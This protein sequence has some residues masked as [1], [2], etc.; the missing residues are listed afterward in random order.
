MLQSTAGTTV[1]RGNTYFGS[2]LKAFSFLF[3]F[4]GII[5]SGLGSLTCQFLSYKD[6]SI[7]T[8][9]G[10]NHDYDIPDEV[11]QRQLAGVSKILL[12]DEGTTEAW[13]GL[14]SYDIVE[15]Y[16]PDAVTER[17]LQYDKQSI[18]G[19][20]P[21]ILLLVAQICALS[22]PTMALLAVVVLYLQFAK[23]CCCTCNYFTISLMFLVSAGFQATTFLLFLEPNFCDH[24]ASCSAGY[25]AWLS[26][27]SAS[28]L[29]AC[30]FLLGCSTIIDS[31][32]NDGRK[33]L[34]RNRDTKSVGTDSSSAEDSAD[35]NP[36]VRT[37]NPLVRRFR[38]WATTPGTYFVDVEETM[39]HQCNDT[40]ME[41]FKAAAVEVDGLR[42]DLAR[43]KWSE[44]HEL[45]PPC[46]D[47]LK[48]DLKRVFSMEEPTSSFVTGGSTLTSA[49]TDD[50]THLTLNTFEE[51]R[52][53]RNPVV[54]RMQKSIQSVSH[55]RR[56][57]KRQVAAEEM[58]RS[59]CILFGCG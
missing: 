43:Q 59:T 46:V 12:L 19:D 48:S 11:R 55:S 40:G 24:D 25:G 50:F 33:R 26:A 16:N 42:R 15:S 1:T 54:S 18:F 31:C 2:I 9:R 56:Q 28:S 47:V 7:R 5:L 34:S 21:Y 30:S 51:E 8:T 53:A 20:A 57:K 27:S 49:F 44:L 29:F 14:F 38:T 41:E 39:Q 3:A 35:M 13:I 58:P 45:D 10:H 36:V 17:C 22:A 4:S 32:I 6:L 37:I 23:Q 52:P